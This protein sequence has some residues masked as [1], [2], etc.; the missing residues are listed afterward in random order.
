[1]HLFGGDESESD[2]QVNTASLSENQDISA[3][4]TVDHVIHLRKYSTTKPSIHFKVYKSD[5]LETDQETEEEK[6]KSFFATYLNSNLG[7]GVEYNEDDDEGFVEEKRVQEMQERPL[8]DGVGCTPVHRVDLSWPHWTYK[9]RHL[10]LTGFSSPIFLNKQFYIDLIFRLPYGKTQRSESLECSIKMNADTI[11]LQTQ[12]K[13]QYT[14][15]TYNILPFSI[16]V[17]RERSNL[18]GTWDKMIVTKG[19]S[20]FVPG[21]Q[22]ALSGGVSSV[23]YNPIF[24]GDSYG[25]A[26]CN[27]VMYELHTSYTT[28]P[29]VTRLIN[30]DFDKLHAEV[31]PH[32]NTQ[33]NKK[34]EIRKTSNIQTNLEF[35]VLSYFD[36]IVECIQDPTSKLRKNIFNKEKEAICIPFL[37]IS[38]WITKKKHLVD[39][40]RRLMDIKDLQLVIKPASTL[41]TE[42]VKQKLDTNEFSLAKAEYFCQIRMHYIP[43]KIHH[44]QLN[45]QQSA[46]PVNNSNTVRNNSSSSQTNLL[47]LQSPTSSSSSNSHVVLEM[48]TTNKRSNTNWSNLIFP[49]L[50]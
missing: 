23:A 39:K 8:G 41:D 13:V 40:E 1:M 15:D 20:P 49:T 37:A 24:S 14:N 46:S 2:E 6:L 7:E 26:I 42:F 29:D 31:E 47:P 17:I 25:D 9:E 27:P 19:R 33:S 45:P 22:C 32:I 28:N 18:P 12:G 44:S 38:E 4:L 35:I 16:E 5:F 3:H 21:A 34:L 36:E 43:L 50:K 48:G 30:V 11:A 10:G